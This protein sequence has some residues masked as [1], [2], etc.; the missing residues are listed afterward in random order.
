M[1]MEAVIEHIQA[2]MVAYGIIALCILPVLYLGRKYVVPFVLYTLEILIYISILHVTVYTIVRVGAWFRDSSSFD[3]AFG[4]ASEQT[5]WTTPL[6]EFWDQEAY[7]PSWVY[8]FEIVVA[9][10]IVIAVFRYR[11]MKIHK[12]RDR[13]YTDTGKRIGAGGK[14]GR[15][16]MAGKGPGGSIPRH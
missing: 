15:G 7:D 9:V 3:N 2:N 8:W 16:K 12:G 5:T 4:R 13:R 14:A 6:L 1:E 10:M 11:P